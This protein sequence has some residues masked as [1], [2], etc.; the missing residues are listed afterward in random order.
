MAILLEEYKWY[1][2]ARIAGVN[3]TSANNKVPPGK[4]DEDN[5]P[6]EVALNKQDVLQSEIILKI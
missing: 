6:I 3:P 1:I 2:V 5:N 4:K